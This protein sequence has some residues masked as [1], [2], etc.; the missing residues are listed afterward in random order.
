MGRWIKRLAAALAVL[1]VLVFAAAWL[2]PWP[3]VLVI[4]Q[5]FDAGARAAS[6][7]LEKHLPANVRSLNDIAYAPG[8][9]DA[10][11]DIH[12]PS[13][14]KGPFPVILWIHGGAWVSGDKS[15]LT[16]YLKI[17]AARGYG[18]VNIGYS[19]APGATYPTPV[20]QANAALGF[21]VREGARYGLDP[22][23]IVLAG[24][25]AG[26]QLAAQLAGIVTSADYADAV[27]IT[28]SPLPAPLR[29]VLL[30]CGPYD[31]G[32]VNFDGPFGTFLYTVVWA[33]SGSRDFRSDPAFALMSVAQHV[34]PAF[35][36]A[37]I[38]V[39]NADPLRPQSVQ[40][41]EALRAKGGKVE[42]LFFPDAYTPPLAHEYQFDL[43]TAAGQ[44][45]LRRSAA[46]LVGVMRDA[47]PQQPAEQADSP[48]AAESGHK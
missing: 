5:I 14:G 47:P 29:G 12:L 26:A 34:T 31:V 32:K 42:T 35:P 9:P 23:R 40:L 4:R 46:W 44:L 45:A 19:I 11:L 6:A 27:G 21:V 36:P 37:F 20:R 2:S 38:S 10:R 8:D 28:P 33:Y 48:R 18:V 25:S 17:L 43:D 39:G 13:S 15:D 3:G 22:T 41:A 7:K 1:V 16:N 30:Y 24:D